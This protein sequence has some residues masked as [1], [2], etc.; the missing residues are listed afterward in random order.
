MSRLDETFAALRR[1]GERALLAY[2][3]AGDPSLAETRRLVAA[4]ALVALSGCVPTG[5]GPD[6]TD[7]GAT[8]TDDIDGDLTAAIVVTGAVDTATEGLYTLTYTATDAAG[9]SANVSRVVTVNV[10]PS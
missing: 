3:T 7:P 9:N 8:A 6:R 2:F 5:G 10:A 1:R 4:A